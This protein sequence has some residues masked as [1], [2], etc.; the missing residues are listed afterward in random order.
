MYRLGVMPHWEPGMPTAEPHISLIVP[1]YN[2]ENYL[3]RTLQSVNQAKE[4]YRD[5]SSIEVVVVN[6]MATDRRGGKTGLRGI[7]SA[8]TV[9]LA[10]ETRGNPGV[11][12]SFG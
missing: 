6:N 1:A 12:G 8:G 10:D 4:A 3:A 11:R 7:P 5:P 9:L 2:E